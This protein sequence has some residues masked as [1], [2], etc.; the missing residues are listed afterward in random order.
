MRILG[1][2]QSEKV[3]KRR[4]LGVGGCRTLGEWG[5]GSGEWGVGSGEWGRAIAPQTFLW[6]FTV[7]RSVKLASLPGCAP[8]KSPN[9][10]GL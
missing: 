8:P 1:F 3:G 10:G 6:H 7:H 5:V 9:S 4:V 2:G